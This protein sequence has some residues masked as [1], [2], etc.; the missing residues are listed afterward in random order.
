MYT[1]QKTELGKLRTYERELTARYAE[2]LLRKRLGE[3]H[4]LFDRRRTLRRAIRQA[5]AGQGAPATVIPFPRQAA[6]EEELAR[7]A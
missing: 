7:A 1:A 2:A 6:V 3:A 5:E 4:A